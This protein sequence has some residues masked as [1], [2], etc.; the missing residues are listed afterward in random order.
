MDVVLAAGGAPWEAA[1]IG[2]IEGSS[3]LRLARRCVD[4]ADLLAVAQTDVASAAL[5]HTEL[6]GLDADAVHRLERAGRA[7]RR[8]R[9]RRST[10]ASVSASRG[11]CSIGALDALTR[12][13]VAPD[14]VG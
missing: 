1:A 8:G 12:D 11:A 2:E 9:G 6:S 7:S 13:T 3:K 10:A 4:V 14:T 5:V